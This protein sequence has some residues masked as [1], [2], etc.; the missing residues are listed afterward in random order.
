MQA[1][2]CRPET[3]L[4]AAAA[5]W[6]VTAADASADGA[7]DHAGLAKTSL[8]R[9]IRPGY[10]ALRS[11]GIQLDRQIKGLCAE[12]GEAS[13][14]AA[15]AAFS[16]FVSAWGRI[17]HIRFGPIVEENRLE[18]ILFWPDRQG[19][20]AR[21][22]LRILS[23]RDE[24]ATD[25]AKL[26]TKSVAVQ[27][28]GA[29]EIMLYGEGREALL[30]LDADGAFRCRYA[31][32]SA[33]SLAGIAQDVVAAWS[34]AS[35]VSAQWLAPGSG[36]TRYLRAEE[37]TAELAK[38]LATGLERV[39]D[40]RIAGPLGLGASRRK[41]TPILE[42]S[43]T[44]GPLITANIEGLEALFSEGGLKQAISATSGTHPRVLVADNA[45][46]VARELVTARERLVSALRHPRPFQRPDATQAFI[47][48]G[49][50]LKNANDIAGWMLSL[51]AGVTMG[52]NASD[53]D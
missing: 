7:F 25:A 19:I 50:P 48:V 41:E 36:N 11:A 52:F 51:T 46:L 35:G 40:E 12:P 14:N 16:G 33:S 53:G 28:I 43:D 22:V 20:G 4:A 3:L 42:R 8:E 23:A 31:S 21:E 17:E 29:L 9:H 5:I 24:A 30:K 13:W 47:G 26:A 1:A 49:F 10:D 27:G 32:A 44:T 45:D 6:C 37:T 38:A 34:L 39:R 15:T 2:R 18:R